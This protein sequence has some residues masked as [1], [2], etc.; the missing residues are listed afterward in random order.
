MTM[1]HDALTIIISILVPMIGGFGWLI[2]RMDKNHKD[3]KND[4]DN[5]HRDLRSLDSRMSRL[6][7]GFSERGYWESRGKRLGEDE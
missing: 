7:G 5:I 1:N 2:S 4:I 3:L 6:E